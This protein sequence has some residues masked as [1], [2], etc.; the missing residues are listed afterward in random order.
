MPTQTV[1]GCVRVCIV[2]RLGDIRMSACSLSA[3]GALSN[4]NEKV[5]ANGV[6]INECV[7]IYTKMNNV[8]IN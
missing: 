2:F 7:I 1:S 6:E 4:A 3:T 8:R 5:R